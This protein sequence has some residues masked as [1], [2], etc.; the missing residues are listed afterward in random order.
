MINWDVVYD[1]SVLA[2]CGLLLFV[3]GFCVFRSGACGQAADLAL[4]LLGSLVDR[5]QQARANYKHEQ[6]ISFRR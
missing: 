3:A 6:S 2:A 1:A 4:R 5:A